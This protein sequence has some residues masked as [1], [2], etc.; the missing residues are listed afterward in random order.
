[1]LESGAYPQGRVLCSCK[2]YCLNNGSADFETDADA[3][4]SISIGQ[5]VITV[6]GD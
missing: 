3:L 4:A 5:E 2:A 1:M 6:V